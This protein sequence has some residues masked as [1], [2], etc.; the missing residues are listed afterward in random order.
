VEHRRG[1][2]LASWACWQPFQDLGGDVQRDVGDETDFEQHLMRA[3]PARA[4]RLITIPK[5]EDTKPT[6]I[7]VRPGHVTGTSTKGRTAAGQRA[8]GRAKSRYQDRARS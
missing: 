8:A 3:L 7:H 4:V 6:R 1:T 5:A 2:R